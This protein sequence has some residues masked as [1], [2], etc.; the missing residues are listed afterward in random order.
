MDN[1][2]NNKSCLQ[3]L[4]ILLRAREIEFDASDRL[5][6]C[7]PHVIHICVT[8]VVKS[9]TG[10]DLTAIAR[11]WG[12]T[13]SDQEERK[14]YVA[15]VK[16]NP[17]GMCR[18]AVRAIRASG[19]RRDEFT[20]TIKTG[21]TKNWYKDPTGNVVKVPELELLRDVSTR[22]D[23]MFTMINRLRALRPVSN[24]DANHSSIY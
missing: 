7:F 15:A 14:T 10:A 13:F 22:W 1:A 2:S 3:E 12:S 20:D 21:N 5:V 23:S 16:S 24:I 19:M 17:I 4:E 8:H 11:A 18:D 6:A 9:F